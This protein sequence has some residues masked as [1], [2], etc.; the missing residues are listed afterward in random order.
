MAVL[1]MEPR[2]AAR[3]LLVDRWTAAG[4]ISAAALGIGLNTAVFAVAY[5]VP[6]HPL[7][8][9]DADESFFETLVAPAPAGRPFVR[10]DSPAVAAVSERFVRDV[11]ASD[12]TIVRQRLTVA[13][14]ALT[15]RCSAGSIRV[16]IRSDRCLDAR[17]RR[18]RGRLRPIA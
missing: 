2:F 1:L 10:G 7:P 3:R 14:T 11:G 4:A 8:Y 13:E 15:C 17:A 18:A 16:S 12:D 5:G 6:L 9:A